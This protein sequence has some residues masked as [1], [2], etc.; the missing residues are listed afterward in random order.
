MT[1]RVFWGVRAAFL[2]V[3]VALTSVAHGQEAST[4]TGTVILTIAGDIFE[5]ESHSVSTR[6]ATPSSI[7]MK[8]SLIARS[9]SINPCLTAEAGNRQGERAPDRRAG[10]AQGRVALRS[11][12][13]GRGENGASINAVALDGYTKEI[14]AEKIGAHDWILAST[15]D[16]NPLVIGDQGPLWMVYPPSKVDVPKDEEADWPW[17]L[18]YIEVK[19]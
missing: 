5:D 10:R 14:S 17:A 12:Q 8:S 18:F 7:F 11:L 2:V 9:S 15:S 4:P 3:V 6:N 19:K 16:G 1:G 13:A